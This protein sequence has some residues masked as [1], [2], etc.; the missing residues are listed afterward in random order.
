MVALQYILNGKTILFE[1]ILNSEGR[2]VELSLND[3][4]YKVSVIE[5]RGLQYIIVPTF[6]LVDDSFIKNNNLKSDT[7]IM[8]Y[9]LIVL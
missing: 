5:D 4:R 9:E 2:L 6:E 8:L 3:I 1:S 7:L